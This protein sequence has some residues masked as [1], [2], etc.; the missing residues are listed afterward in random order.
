MKQ[1]IERKMEMKSRI[2]TLLYNAHKINLTPI[3]GA[4]L[5]EI[6]QS[7]LD[8]NITTEFKKA[9]RKIIIAN[10]YTDES[11]KAVLKK[12]MSF[13]FCPDAQMAK[14]NNE[15]KQLC[16]QYDVHNP[17]IYRNYLYDLLK[18][19]KSKHVTRYKNERNIFVYC[20]LP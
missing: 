6:Q 8:M 13:Y 5:F 7:L 16:K 15:I 18:N 17:A 12:S 3:T 2:E 1:F 19:C 4:K 11:W 9:K 20:W 10:G 14:A